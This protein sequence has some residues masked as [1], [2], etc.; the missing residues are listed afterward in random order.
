MQQ[1]N[2]ESA[3]RVDWD[4]NVNVQQVQYP[5]TV[6]WLELLYKKYPTEKLMSASDL[7]NYRKI[8]ETTNAFRKKN[9]DDQPIRRLKTAKYSG[10][11]LTL[12]SFKVNMRTWG[13]VFAAPLDT[14]A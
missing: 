1:D 11:T 13:T 3:E 4:T 7:Q 14:S 5:K 12:G 2:L 10:G 8:I 6:G 9:S